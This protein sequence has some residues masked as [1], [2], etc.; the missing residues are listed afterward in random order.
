MVFCS[1]LSMKWTIFSINGTFIPFVNY[2]FLN[3]DKYIYTR[4]ACDTLESLWELFSVFPVS[5][6]LKV[7]IRFC[8]ALQ[9]C[10]IITPTSQSIKLLYQ[11]CFKALIAC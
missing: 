9:N 10:Y 6:N 2:C 5:A 8:V 3:T 1:V 4:G 11:K 7:L